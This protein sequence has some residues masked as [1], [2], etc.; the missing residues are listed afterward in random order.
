MLNLLPFDGNALY[1]PDAFCTQ[2]SNHYFKLL[3]K[4]IAWQADQVRMFGKS[5]TLRRKIA[6]Y[7]D[8]AFAYRYS[9]STKVALPW[10]PALQTI[11]KHVEE[12]SGESFN[13]CLLNYY[14]DGNDSMGWHSDNEKMMK[15]GASIASVSFGAERV[16]KFKHNL[17]K[18]VTQITLAH[19]SLLLMQGNIQEHW[20]HSLPASKKITCPRINL[21]FR[22][23]DTRYHSQ[24][25]QNSI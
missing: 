5:L 3:E 7:G 14:H 23:F 18:D 10:T 9:Q 16:F 8:D 2:E 13:S 11:K 20:K 4:G 21:T 15:T 6:W 1:Y 22:V 24:I 19:G 17:N 25:K 12:V